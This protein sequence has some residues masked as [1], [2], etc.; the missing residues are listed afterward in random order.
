MQTPNFTDGQFLDMNTLNAAASLV[1]TS[2]EMV[3]S[4]TNTPGLISPGAL[5]FTPS[6]LTVEVTAPSPFAVC[7]SDGVLAQAF[8]TTNGATSD[9][10]TVNFAPLV[11]GSGSVTAYIIASAATVQQLPFQDTGPPI[12][13]PDFNPNF[14][15]FEAFASTEDTLS[16]T[17]SLTAPNNTTTFE[18][19]RVTLTAGETNIASVN[20]AFQV[21]ASSILNPTGVAPGTYTGATVTV[22]A[23]GRVTAIV[24][25]AYGP[26]AAANTWTA[27]QT[28][29][30]GAVAS[31]LTVDRKS[32]V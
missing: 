29:S 30:D 18:L 19:G 32:V 12:G 26:L 8:G 27:P 13:H 20:T 21:E 1:E 2:I 10:A 24:D 31:T 5:T 15:P 28:F 22:G 14:V 25:V 17:A 9:T 11:P 7:F 23:D 3:T 16:I 4:L 6:A